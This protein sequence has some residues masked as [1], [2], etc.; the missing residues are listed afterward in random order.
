MVLLLMAGT[1]LPP[2][3]VSACANQGGDAGSSSDRGR[4]E[5]SRQG[6]CS[7]DLVLALLRA[8]GLPK[9]LVAAQVCYKIF[10]NSNLCAMCIVELVDAWKLCG[11]TLLL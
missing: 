8:Q 4:G 1:E 6:A 9:V 3:S 7:G 11:I 2:S 5:H 10:W